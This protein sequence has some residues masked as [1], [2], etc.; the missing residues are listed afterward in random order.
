MHGVAELHTRPTQRSVDPKLG[1]ALLGKLQG[2][3]IGEV[4][5]RYRPECSPADHVP[6]AVVQA[7]N[8]DLA[9]H[10]PVDG[11]GLFLGRVEASLA[12]EFG[13]RTEHLWH[14]GAGDGRDDE[15]VEVVLRHQIGA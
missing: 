9:A 14:T 6:R 3:L 2:F 1:E 12:D 5:Q 13:E 8:R 15:T 4:A 11:D 10:G 7:L